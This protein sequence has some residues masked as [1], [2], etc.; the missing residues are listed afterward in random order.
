MKKT[1]PLSFIQSLF[2]RLDPDR[3]QAQFL[4]TLMQI[5]DVERGSVWIRRGDSYVCSEAAGPESDKVK[6]LAISTRRPSI[7]G[8]VFE[9]GKMTIAEVGKDPRHFKEVENSLNVKSTLI[10]C[11]PL[12]LKDGSVYGAV[13]IIDTSAGGNRLNL[14]PDYLGLLE[15]LVTTGGIALSASLALE[16]QQKENVKLRKILLEVRSPP[17]IIGR[18]ETF[19]A[20]LRTAEAYAEEDFPVLITGESG[21]GKELVAREIHRHSSRRERPFLAQNCSAIP[22]TLLESELF[23]YRKGAFTGATRDKV[24]LFQ[25]AHGGTVFLDE[26]GDMALGLQAKIL[27]VMQSNEVKPLGGSEYQKVDMR[28]ISATNRNL[29]RSIEMGQFREDLYF[30]LNVLPLVM[31]P[32]RERKDDIPM[33]VNHFLLHYA[34]VTGRRFRGIAPEAMERMMKY[35][36]PGNIREMENMVKYLLTVARHDTIHL[37]DLPTFFELAPHGVPEPRPDLAFPGPGERRH[38]AP[39]SAYSWEG[40]ERDYIFSLLEGTKWN[41]TAAARK[42][43]VK[44]STFTAR[45]K[46]LGI[47]KRQEGV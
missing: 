2:D 25:A 14:D 37:S 38:A 46:R 28:I 33:L 7:V 13:Q 15:G 45:M 26:I 23:G 22:D 18:S 11:F 1:L 24:G 12:K 47:S 17:P 36:W 19:L 44:R 34:K 21:T 20:V 10:L 31:P 39:L 27:S 32:L 42:A 9:T 43:D 30:R 16:N 35:H 4:K 5:Q 41:I 29:T 8:S 6:G 40:L 3:F